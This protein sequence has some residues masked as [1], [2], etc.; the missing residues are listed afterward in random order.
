MPYVEQRVAELAGLTLAGSYLAG[1]SVADTLASG[2]RAAAWV[3]ARISHR[4]S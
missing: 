4:V 3:L 1:V 2:V